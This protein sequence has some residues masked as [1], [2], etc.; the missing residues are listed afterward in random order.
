[1]KA[2]ELAEELLKYPDYEVQTSVCV[3]LP[4]YDNPY[5]KCEYCEVYGIDYV[6]PEEKVIILDVG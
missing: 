2:K 5:E 1:M 4:T 3:S 6:I